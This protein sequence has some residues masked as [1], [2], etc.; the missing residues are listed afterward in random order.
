MSDNISL[1]DRE[2]LLAAMKRFA[3]GGFEPADTAVFEDKELIDSFNEMMDRVTKRNNHY[4]ARINDAQSRIGDTSCLKSMFEE[5]TSQESAILALK[6]A[7]SLI[8]PSSE[9]LENTNREFLMLSK[10]ISMAIAPCLNEVISSEKLLDKLYPV[11]SDGEPDTENPLY[12]PLSELR[13]NLLNTHARLESMS[14]RILSLG[15]DATEVFNIIDEKN[16]LNNSFLESVDLLTDS[17]RKLSAEC[18]DTGRHLYRISRDIDNARNDMFRHNSRPTLHDRLRVYE[19]D[20]VT[21]AWRLYNNIV[22]FE[23]LRLT[24]VNNPSSCKFGIWST[25]MEDPVFLESEAFN[26]AV[27]AHTEFHEHCVECYNAKQDYDIPLAFKK[28]DEVMASLKDFLAAMEEL[29][30]YLR[31]IGNTDET[32]V[33]KFRG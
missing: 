4:L 18:L 23:S 8:D 3:D 5:I 33:W 24:Q 28:F 2:N 11:T 13:E 25:T 16:R 20:H 22:E 14:A 1:N 26:K 19:V 6:E 32:D 31:S 29:H 27:Q 21:L 7:R 17:Y 15:K 12:E 30:E 10:Q 9:S